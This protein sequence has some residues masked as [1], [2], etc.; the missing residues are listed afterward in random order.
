MVACFCVY[1]LVNFLCELGVSFRGSII[2][3]IAVGSGLVVRGGVLSG[4]SDV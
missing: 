3:G 2:I 1:Y 4:V